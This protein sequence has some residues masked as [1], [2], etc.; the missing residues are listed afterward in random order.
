ML[1]ECFGDAGPCFDEHHVGLRRGDVELRMLG[2]TRGKDGRVLMILDQPLDMVRDRMAPGRRDNSRLPHSPAHHL[3]PAMRTLD[4]VAAA[5]QQ[6]ADRR[7]EAFRQ[8]DGDRIESFR[9]LLRRN[10]AL[11]RGVPKAR[12]VEMKRKV[13]AV[14]DR[15]HLRDIAV[16]Q[17]FAANGVFERDEARHR[18][19]RIVG[20]DR[21]LD[22]GQRN[23]AVRRVVERLRLDAAQHRATAGLV[24]IVVGALPQDHF[25]AARA[26][27][28]HANQV[29]LRARGHEQRRLEA[30][31]RGNFLLQRIDAGVVA[32]DIVADGCGRHRRTH[33]CRRP[34]NRVAAKIHRHAVQPSLFNCG[35]RI[36]SRIDGLSVRSITR[37]STPIP[38]PAV[39]GSPYS[40][41]RR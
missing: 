32:E 33:R 20:L 28:H 18:K 7:A 29:P 1:R 15:A 16:R 8:A 21:G 34:R 19:V 26:V 3:A 31:Q 13:M 24:P 11:H 4:V 9:N 35:N 25:V 37:R 22:R 2:E 41:A 30:K 6:R 40:I 39:G 23:R 5:A 10:T 17:D 12:A 36:T 14:D 38:S 27:R